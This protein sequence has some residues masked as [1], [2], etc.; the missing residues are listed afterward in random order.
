MATLFNKIVIVFLFS[1][2]SVYA[3]DTP[4]TTQ[5]PPFPAGMR[6]LVGSTGVLARNTPSLSGTCGKDNHACTVADAIPPGQYG[7]VQNDAPVFESSG[8]WWVKVN[9]EN[10]VSGWSSGYPPYLNQLNPPQMAQGFSFRTIADYAGPSI[11]QGICIK[12]G[13][14]SAATLSLQP[15]PNSVGQQG[16]ISCPWTTPAI[17]NHIVVIRAVNNAGVANSSE[18]QFAVTAQVVPQP[19]NT[20]SNLRIA[21][22]TTTVPAGVN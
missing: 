3:Q 21:P 22:L 19:P 13:T 9:Y 10:G 7:V 12:D 14:E 6:L 15:I 4:P 16:T 2:A 5:Y 8:W 11:T 18:F 1:V 20:P 17:G